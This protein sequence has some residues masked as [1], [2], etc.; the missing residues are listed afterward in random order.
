VD[1]W[2]E[3]AVLPELPGEVLAVI[4]PHAGHQYS[5]AVA[6]H[7][8]A[9]LRGRTPGLVAV[10]SPM[11]HPY[12]RPLITT[13]HEAYGTPLGDIPVDRSVVA[14][15]DSALQARL[16]FGLS[17][18]QNDPEHSLE[19]ELRSSNARWPLN[20]AVPVMVHVQEPPVSKPWAMAM[21]KV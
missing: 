9:A 2:L 1:G 6:G 18:V 5:G 19:I 13:A 12:H 11:H 7:A 14:E 15:L 3:S 4:A 20:S 16:G 10:V 17:P 8:F 21:A